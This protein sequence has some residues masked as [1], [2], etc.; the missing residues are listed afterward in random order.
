M[1]VSRGAIGSRITH[2]AS[3]PDGWRFLKLVAA[4]DAHG[5]E[6]LKRW[7]GSWIGQSCCQTE[8]FHAWSVVRGI[9]P[10]DFGIA[11]SRLWPEIGLRRGAVRQLQ[12]VSAGL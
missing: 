9:Q 1:S 2:F 5:I 6:R 4:E 12:T 10:D 3:N 11:A 7:C 8:T